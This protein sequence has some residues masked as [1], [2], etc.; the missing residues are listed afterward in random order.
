MPAANVDLNET[1]ER[2]WRLV[3][4]HRWWIVGTATVVALATVAVQSFLPNRFRSE[5]TLVVLRQQVNAKYVEPSAMV[6]PNDA[7]INLM[8]EILSRRRLLGI[9]DEFGLYAKERAH[10]GPEEV[11]D[12][13]RADIDLDSVDAIPGRTDFS[14]FKIAFTGSTAELARDVTNRLTSLFI[15]GNSKARGHEASATTSF[16][17]DQV[18]N[19]KRLVAVQEGRLRAFKS[20]YLGELPEQQG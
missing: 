2:L 4:M 3:R 5:A 6:S 20:Q 12:M 8:A 15:E 17:T 7:V 11:A 13:M 19:A 1:V 10:L 9:V 18:A 16:L 14:T